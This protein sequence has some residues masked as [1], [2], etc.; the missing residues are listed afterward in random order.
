[1]RLLRLRRREKNGGWRR[2]A[3]TTCTAQG[4]AATQGALCQCSAEKKHLTVLHPTHVKHSSHS[5]LPLK[6]QERGQLRSY[7]IHP[8]MAECPVL[9]VPSLV[10]DFWHR[11]VMAHRGHH[12][13]ET[14]KLVTRVTNPKTTTFG[15]VTHVLWRAHPSPMQKC[16]RNSGPH[17]ALDWLF[18]LHA[19][20]SIQRKSGEYSNIPTTL[21]PCQYRATH[22]PALLGNTS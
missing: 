2:E 7:R 21:A 10:N 8:C 3:I 18:A 9:F 4:R 6:S 14:P 11:T 12:R 1:V 15:H 20:P 22:Y 19:P 5:T 16:N 17:A 13:V